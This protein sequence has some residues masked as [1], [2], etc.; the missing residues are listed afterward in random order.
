[1]PIIEI[2]MPEAAKRAEGQ[3]VLRAFLTNNRLQ[4]MLVRAFEDPET[5]GMLLADVAR[6]LAAVFAEDG[7]ITEA[8]VREKI[9]A[10]F[11]LEMEK[12]VSSNLSEQRRN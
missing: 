8:Q 6:R 12:A 2:P 5:W 3:E 4:V 9:A 11:N 1:M 7:K 10:T